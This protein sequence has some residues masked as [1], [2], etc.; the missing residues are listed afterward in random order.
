M[1][2]FNEENLK[3]VNVVGSGNL[4]V[5]IDITALYDDLSANSLYYNP[6]QFP[7]LQIQFNSEMPTCNLF[8]SGKYTIV[9][10]KSYEKLY[11]TQTRLIKE[12]ANFDILSPN[13]KDNR[14]DIRNIVCT[15][16]T[17]KELD[18]N[19]VS[20]ELG[21]ENVEYEP[22]QSPFVVYK[23]K[24]SGATLTIPA[25]GS[26]MITG[27]IEEKEAEDVVRQLLTVLNND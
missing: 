17:D 10:A 1:S 12:L 13:H 14:F 2:D 15:Y 16:K 26:I 11:K 23:P 25:S 20:I 4:D 27:I 7:G 6:E 19:R 21:L 3:L 24:G 8:T 9:G 5:E 22:E 18:L